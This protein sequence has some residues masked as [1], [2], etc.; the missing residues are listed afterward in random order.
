MVTAAIE[1]LAYS[2]KSPDVQ[3]GISKTS[4]KHRNRLCYFRDL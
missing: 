1:R 3:K 4:G 2:G